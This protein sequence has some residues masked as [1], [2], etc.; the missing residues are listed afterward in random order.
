[1]I[2]RPYIEADDPALMALERQ[3]PR[4]EPNSFVHYRRRFVD[5]AA[6]FS[7]FYLLLIESQNDIVAVASAG[8]KESQ[9][10]GQ[11]LRLGYIFDVRVSPSMR[12]MGLAATLVESL[13]EDLQSMGCD[14]CYAHIVA[15]NVASLRLFTGMGYER[16]RQLRY[17][18]YQPMPLLIGEPIEVQRH[19]TPD[20]ERVNTHYQR[21]DLFVDDVSNAVLE[22]DFERWESAAA[23]TISLYDQSQVF[24]QTPY[25]A[26]WP[27]PEEI[28]RRGRHWRLFHPIGEPE[29]LHALFEAVRDQAVTE[30]IDKLT[31]LVDAEDPL[32]AFFYAETSDQR[33]YVVVTRSFSDK[34]DGTFGPR[35]YCDTREL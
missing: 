32:P 22:Y 4:G 25:D 29:P 7:D 21:Y 8:I 31:M 16:R 3:C 10:R 9:V 30:N 14:G 27:T 11:A 33:E 20:C 19:P 13:E 34:W 12:R 28:A 17:L 24:Q 23:A 1:M 5:R 26:P 15:T 35:L 6:L 18:T 2:I